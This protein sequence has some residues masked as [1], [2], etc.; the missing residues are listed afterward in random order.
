[1]LGF[2]QND[3][4]A[5]VRLLKSEKFR[6]AATHLAKAKASFE[7]KGQ[8]E[9]AAI[10]AAD[11]ADTLIFLGRLREAEAVL[12]TCVEQSRD[13][14]GSDSVQY[15]LVLASLADVYFVQSDF[16]YA[17]P[18]FEESVTI[19]LSHRDEADIDYLPPLLSFSI[20][21]GAVGLSDAANEIAEHTIDLARVLLGDE[22]AT[23]LAMSLLAIYTEKRWGKSWD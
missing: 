15:A 9:M 13:I 1:M 10:C 23:S 4:A 2:L 22:Q 14:F 18:L 3:Y 19:L 16:D 21:L 7:R 11:Y 17:L 8:K 5:G 6:E 20:C 12:S